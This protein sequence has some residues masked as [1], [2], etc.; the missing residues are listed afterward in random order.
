MDTC[1][2]QIAS[3]PRILFAHRFDT[4]QY[5]MRVGGAEGE[6]EICCILSGDITVDNLDTGESFTVPAGSVVCLPYQ[7]I[8]YHCHS[9]QFHRHVTAAVLVEHTLVQDGGLILPL[10]MTFGDDNG[11]GERIR[12]YLEM[13][14]R[15]HSLRQNGNM[16]YARAMTLLGMV[17]EAYQRQCMEVGVYG[18]DWYV[19]RA[20]QYVAEHIAEPIR[21]PDVAAYLE[22][23][24]GYLSHIFTETAGMT[25]S[26]YINTVRVEQI[27]TMA[28]YYGMPLR[29]AAM[30]VGIT[31]PN[32][33][34]RLFRSIR[35]YTVSEA[36]R[37]RTET[38]ELRQAHER[39]EREKTVERYRKNRRTA[40]TK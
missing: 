32:Y 9:A 14:A 37:L 25:L 23:T 15:D 33:A 34:S 39:A 20:R 19:S 28:V 31:D 12:D 4:A 27:E 26:S 29:E 6:I 17:S 24:P 10:Y 13:L 8:R 40:K 21:V 30:R 7:G 22:I 1:H 35:G 18:N 5:D 16:E 11:D 2:I 36:K 3:V 38:V